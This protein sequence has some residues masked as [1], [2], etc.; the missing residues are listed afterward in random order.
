MTPTRV[1]NMF[2]MTDAL[3]ASDA[4]TRASSLPVHPYMCVEIAERL[5]E[6]RCGVRDTAR[7]DR[8]LS[9][10]CARGYDVACRAK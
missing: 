5:R 2:A 10:A 8:Y 3:C 1:E 4:N 7:A 6:G 9:H